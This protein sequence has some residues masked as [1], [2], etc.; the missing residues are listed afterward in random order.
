[1]KLTRKNPITEV[2]GEDFQKKLEKEA[3]SMGKVSKDYIKIYTKDRIVDDPFSKTGKAVEKDYISGFKYGDNVF[4]DKGTDRI[5]IDDQKT[6]N[7]L[8][9]RLTVRPRKK[10]K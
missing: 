9:G 3:R 1:M 10:K 2:F 8:E 6:I 7:V 4:V 5:L